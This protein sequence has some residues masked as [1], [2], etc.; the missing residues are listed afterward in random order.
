MFAKININMQ[1]DYFDQDIGLM[2]RI[3]LLAFARVVRSGYMAI[4]IPF[5][6]VAFC[7]LQKDYLTPRRLVNNPR[8]WLVSARPRLGEI[9]C[10][11]ISQK[12]YRLLYCPQRESFSLLLNLIA[13]AVHVIVVVLAVKLPSQSSRA[14]IGNTINN[15][16]CIQLGS[17]SFNKE[18]NLAEETS[19]DS[20]ARLKNVEEPTSTE[21][22]IGGIQPPAFI[23]AE[24]RQ[25]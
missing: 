10:L 11:E 15:F 24:K 8:L 19:S 23:L 9:E 22:Q 4:A 13:A 3:T 18:P 16:S 12:P 2:G 5:V 1:L 20:I 25:D 14:A 7:A 6:T 17:S 21:E